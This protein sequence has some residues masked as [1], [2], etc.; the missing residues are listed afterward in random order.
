MTAQSEAR[1]FIAKH[2][3]GGTTPAWNDAITELAALLLAAEARGIERA[4]VVA[5]NYSDD[6]QLAG[7][8]AS[9][10]RALKPGDG[11]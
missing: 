6:V 3:R 2:M 9:K 1:A 7:L 10:I 4:A 11:T 5:E 8:I